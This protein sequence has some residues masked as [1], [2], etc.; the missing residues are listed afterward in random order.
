MKKWLTQIFILLVV[1]FLSGVN[2]PVLAQTCSNPDECQK[3]IDELSGKITILQ[4][5]ANT[6]SNQVKQFDAQIKLTELKITQTQETIEL[7]GGRIDQLE[8]S[9]GDLS[10]AFSSR[11][12]ET[13]K[14]A[15]FGDNFSFI[16]AA[17]DLS[18]AVFRDHYLKKVQEADRDLMS[19]LQ[20]AQNSYKDQKVQSEELQKK[21]EEQKRL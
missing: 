19:R 14:M 20:K 15:R 17:K 21:L 6:L 12:V 5:Q 1:L 4:G 3:L 10:K 11:A 8:N 18:Q 13:Y 7:L 9:L 16:V 2:S